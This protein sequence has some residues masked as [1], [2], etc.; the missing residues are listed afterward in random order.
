[1]NNLSPLDEQLEM[2]LEYCFSYM[3]VMKSVILFACTD[4][5]TYHSVLMSSV[6]KYVK[7]VLVLYL[8]TVFKCEGRTCAYTVEADIFVGV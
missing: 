5:D 3:F 1:M 7:Q 6:L 4:Y 8:S 2:V